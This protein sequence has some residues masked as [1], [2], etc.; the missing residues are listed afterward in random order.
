MIFTFI[1]AAFPPRHCPS[2]S[3]IVYP[4]IAV[5]YKCI[6]SALLPVRVRVPFDVP[7]PSFD[8]SA[9]PLPTLPGPVSLK[10]SHELSFCPRSFELDSSMM[11]FGRHIAETYTSPHEPVI[12]SAHSALDG[13]S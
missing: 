11:I 3:L 8:N 13:K 10:K 4:S 2:F 9:V 7:R 5:S 12:P 6:L 1:I